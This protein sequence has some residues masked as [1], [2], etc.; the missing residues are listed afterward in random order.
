MNLGKTVALVVAFCVISTP[1]FACHSNYFDEVFTKA[2]KA[3]LNKAQL[4]QLK[5]MQSRML[6]S[7]HQRALK[8]QG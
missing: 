5:S 3:N 1:L 7:D 4:V 8:K 2:I 6:A